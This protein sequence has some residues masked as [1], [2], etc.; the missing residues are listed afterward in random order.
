MGLFDVFKG[1]GAAAEKKAA[2]A[3][4]APAVPAAVDAAEA[5]GVLCAP[6]AGRV[7][8]MADVPDPVF[9]GGMLGDGCG[10][11]PSESVVYSPLSGEV[12]VAMS[13]AVDIAG[14]GVEALVHV[15]LDT[16]EMGGDGFELFVKP[17][18]H[19]DAGQPLAR[20][21]RDKIAAAGHKD[22]VVVAVSNSAELAGVRLAAEAG[23]TVPAGAAL[24]E[25]SA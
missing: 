13:H 5:P 11:W 25:V 2:A 17:G 8:A 23:S 24:L 14:A 21:D 19:V 15:G 4:A 7:V 22:C 16:V 1:V 18:D 10:V 3:D 6:V 12:T 9:A 20:I